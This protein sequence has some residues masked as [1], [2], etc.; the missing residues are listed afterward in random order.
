MGGILGGPIDYTK[1]GYYD[2]T[3]PANCVFVSTVHNGKFVPDS[4]KPYC[5]GPIPGTEAQP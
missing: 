4:D 1:W 2:P 5:G 3:A